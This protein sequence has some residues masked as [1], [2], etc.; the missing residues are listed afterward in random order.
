MTIS[1]RDSLRLIA[2]S[3]ATAKLRPW[4]HRLPAAVPTAPVRLPLEEFVETPRLLNAYRKAVR[5]MNAR[6]PSDPLSWFYQAAIHGVSDD[7]RAKA[8]AQDPGVAKVDS[9]FWNQCPHNGQNSANFLPWHRGYTHFLE[10]I[11]RLHAEEDD[12]ALPYWNFTEKGNRQFPRVF[13]IQH[14]DGNLKNDAPSNINPLYLEERDHY[15]CSYEHPFAE[16]LPLLELGDRAVDISRPMGSPIFFGATEREGLGGGIADDDPTTRGLLESYPHDQIHRAV[17]GIVLTPGSSEPSAGAMAVPPTAA[18][19]PIFAVVHAN[20]DRLWVEWSLMSGKTWG[21]LPSVAWFNERPWY[22]VDRNGRVVN[23]PRWKYFDHRALGVRF[24][25]ED[26]SREPLPLPAN[27][28]GPKVLA[29][30]KQQPAAPKPRVEAHADTA[31]RV[32]PAER[33][34]VALPAGLRT[35]ARADIALLGK[36][37]TPKSER[38]LLRLLGV[39]LNQLEGSGFDVYLT[40]NPADSLS[41]DRASFL[42]SIELFRHQARPGERPDRMVIADRN[43]SFDA[44]RAVAGLSDSAIAQL[45]LVFVPYSLFSTPYPGAAAARGNS[46]TFTGIELARV[47]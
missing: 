17:G 19:D 33:T 16:G 12:F 21:V 47:P 39:Q 28:T 42:G 37:T 32:S 26:M 40:S 45:R 29:L 35:A 3:L 10:Q 34:V 14:L 44:T 25:D 18:F 38:V 11:V 4:S 5:A 24:K 8:A 36:A 41:R 31:V 22:F 23:E 30:A 6:K 20:I 43:E 2:V 7:A 27:V 15:F 13:G 46:V 1:R 9:K